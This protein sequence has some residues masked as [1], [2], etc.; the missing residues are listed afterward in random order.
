MDLF[1]TNI[2]KIEKYIYLERYVNNGS[3]SGFTNINTTSKGTRPQ[4]DF[5]TFNVFLVKL[6][7]SID[8]DFGDISQLH[9]KK[10]EIL[11][12]PDCFENYKDFVEYKK[13]IPAIPLASMR[14]VYI[15]TYGVF[16]KLQYDKMLGRI[17]RKI[18]EE[19]AKHSISISQIIKES[20]IRNKDEYFMIETGSR[21]VKNDFFSIGMTI[22]EAKLFPTFTTNHMLI[23]A[24]SLF[25]RDLKQSNDM[26]ILEQIYQKQEKNPDDFIFNSFLKPAIEL[27]FNLLLQT[28]L[29]I[30]A[31]AQN[32][33]FVLAD[34]RINGIV[35]RDFES[36]DKD[37]EIGK[38]YNKFF[39][40]KYKC[41]SSSHPEYS[42]RHSF[43]FD[44]K[45]GEYLLEPIIEASIKFGA[46]KNVLYERCRQLSNHFIEKFPRDFFPMDGWYSL[47]KKLIDRNTNFR[48]Y[49]R[50]NPIIFR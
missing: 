47:E 42:K 25:G 44:F 9:L 19:H 32:I 39:N 11:I 3:P 4:D 24:F 28:G 49:I 12:H 27:F 48:G 2:S 8:V 13:D 23:P 35:L 41:F 43:M 22:R 20:Y 26:C 38:K 46:N 6:K 7:D 33:L 34:N 30:E 17:E 15:P 14:T 18:N 36:I 1:N 50:N 37:L 45:L 10:N 5:K 16:I 21:I 31:H 40:M 29:V